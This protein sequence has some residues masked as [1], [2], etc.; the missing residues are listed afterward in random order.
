M[1][2]FNEVAFE[3]YNLYHAVAIIAMKCSLHQSSFLFPLENKLSMNFF[4]MLTR[5][6]KYARAKEAY[7]AYVPPTSPPL[8]APVSI[9]ASPH[10]PIPKE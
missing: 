9:V 7:R 1:G 8:S 3:V 6:K 4:Q 5:A 10:A 2:R